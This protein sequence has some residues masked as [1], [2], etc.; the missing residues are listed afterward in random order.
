MHY[1]QYYYKCTYSAL[2]VVV[3]AHTT[4][5]VVV[6]RGDAK[7]EGGTHQECVTPA[8]I[9]GTELCQT[10]TPMNQARTVAEI[11]KK[12]IA[13][14]MYFSYISNQHHRGFSHQGTTAV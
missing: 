8:L 1:V 12:T 10:D 5:A 2:Q 13:K 4:T 6:Y 9:P 11:L 7:S 14:K 3:T